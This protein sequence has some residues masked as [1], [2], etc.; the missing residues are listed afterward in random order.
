MISDSCVMFFNAVVV[1][2]NRSRTNIGS[3]ADSGITDIRQMWHFRS[4]AKLSIFHFNKSAGFPCV[5][6][7]RARA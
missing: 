2:E 3:L 7:H 6:D 4:G 1:N 5:T